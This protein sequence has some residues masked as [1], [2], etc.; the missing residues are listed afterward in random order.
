MK[1]LLSIVGGLLAGVVAH[2]DCALSNITLFPETKTIKQNPIFLIEGY[3]N[4][5]PII[6]NLNK[7]YRIYLQNGNQRIKLIV[8]ETRISEFRLSQAL[9]KPASVLTA[10]LEYTVVIEGIPAEQFQHYDTATNQREAFRYR[11]TDGFDNEKPALT[12]DIRFVRNSYIEFGCGPSVHIVFSNPATDSSPILVK[13]TVKRIASGK[14]T[15]YYILPAA[16]RIFLG[17]GMCE[18]AFYFVDGQD[19][20]VSFSFMD[21]SGNLA[22]AAGEPIQFTSPCRPEKRAR[23]KHS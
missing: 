23:Q 18:G 22:S 5:Q 8:L 6:R 1:K 13:A 9:L 10:G 12:P 15:T 2:A 11:V 17:H 19:Y 7:T 4:S 20:K 16:D 3:A 21:A 14:E